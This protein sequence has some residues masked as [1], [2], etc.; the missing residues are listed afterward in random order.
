MPLPLRDINVRSESN[1][2]LIDYNILG[3]L[4]LLL[5]R[6]SCSGSHF[7]D[8]GMLLLWMVMCEVGGAECEFYKVRL[9]VLVGN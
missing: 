2:Y 4:L 6:A 8:C 9:G 3:P 5:L 1:S 7:V